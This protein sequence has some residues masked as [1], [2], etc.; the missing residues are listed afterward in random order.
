[1]PTVSSF[2]LGVKELAITRLTFEGTAT[3]IALNC[4]LN[5]ISL[6]LLSSANMDIV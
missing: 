3:S 1:V 4:G 5:S 6:A 2:G